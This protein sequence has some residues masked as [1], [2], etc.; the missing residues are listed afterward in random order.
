MQLICVLLVILSIFIICSLFSMDHFKPINS[1]N[2]K[3]NAKNVRLP[4]E[5]KQNKH[6]L[7]LK[8]K[9]LSE[10]KSSPLGWQN[11]MYSNFKYPYVGAKTPCTDNSQCNISS[12]C[13]YDDD[14]IFN[15]ESGIGVCTLKVPDKT[16]FN[17]KY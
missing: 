16:V 5:L 1:L 2:I 6:D 11:Q 14:N 9:I 10:L 12:E 13:N 15:R 7:S 3:Y 4:N 8:Q 17:I